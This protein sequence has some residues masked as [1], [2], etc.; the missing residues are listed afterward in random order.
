MT[1]GTHASCIQFDNSAFCFHIPALSS[2]WKH[3][4]IK[5]KP[6]QRS[7]T[8]Q[9]KSVRLKEKDLEKDASAEGYNRSL[10]TNPAIRTVRTAR[11]WGHR[12]PDRDRDR[13]VR[14][15]GTWGHRQ[16]QDCEDSKGTQIPRQGQDH[17]GSRDMGTQIPREVQDREDRKGT[18][19]PRQGQT[20]QVQPL[21]AAGLETPGK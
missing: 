21:V 8:A 18:Q 15:V 7:E 11:T 13:T 19:I 2:C 1:P 17:E 4:L 3:L 20:K 9:N 16:G 14:T 6:R 5:T 12:Y 10:L